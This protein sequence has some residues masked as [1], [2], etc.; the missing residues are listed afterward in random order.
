MA[1]SVETSLYLSFSHRDAI[2]IMCNNNTNYFFNRW[3]EGGINV[4]FV[5]Q[6]STPFFIS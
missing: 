5:R 3:Q 1:V 4:A 2:I 6:V